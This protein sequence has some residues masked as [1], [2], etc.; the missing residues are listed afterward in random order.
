[1]EIWRTPRCAYQISTEQ[2]GT[3]ALLLTHNA[4]AAQAVVDEFV[5]LGETL[6]GVS[7]WEYDRQPVLSVFVVQMNKLVFLFG[8]GAA[9]ALL[10]LRKHP[11]WKEE[12][13]KF[14]DVAWCLH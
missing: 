5:L 4:A 3:G 14:N 12:T 13:V 1:M 11:N 7:T 2:A 6:T 10:G 8:W 9:F